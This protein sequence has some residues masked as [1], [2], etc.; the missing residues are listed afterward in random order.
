[1]HVPWPQSVAGQDPYIQLLLGDDAQV[2]DPSD[3]IAVHDQTST[4]IAWITLKNG[5][6]TSTTW[7]SLAETPDLS[8]AGRNDHDAGGW[9][10]P[11]FCHAH[12]GG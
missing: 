4:L 8:V 6:I 11:D 10:V 9:S 1:L 2:R 3:T 5:E 12:Q 7:G